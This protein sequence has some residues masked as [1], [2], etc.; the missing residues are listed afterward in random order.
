VVVNACKARNLPAQV[1]S[2]VFSKAARVVKRLETQL[3]SQTMLEDEHHAFSEVSKR[4]TKSAMHR[5]FLNGGAAAISCH[6]A[7][8]P[9]IQ[10]AAAA[11]TAGSCVHCAARKRLI[12]ATT[13][14]AQVPFPFMMANSETFMII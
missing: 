11:A 2:R 14:A 9:G 13:S 5:A 1:E 8:S 4:P 6:A 10:N 7:S 3:W 12:F